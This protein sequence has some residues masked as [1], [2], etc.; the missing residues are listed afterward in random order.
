MLMGIIAD[1]LTGASDIAGFVAG[2]G[3]DVIQFAGV[4]EEDAGIAGEYAGILLMAS[5]ARSTPS[6]NRFHVSLKI[7]E[8]GLIEPLVMASP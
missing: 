6:Y 5:L 4:P 3:L 1:D 2:E 8:P 7:P